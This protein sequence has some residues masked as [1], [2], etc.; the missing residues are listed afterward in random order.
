MRHSIELAWTAADT[1]GSANASRVG[2]A[3]CSYVTLLTSP[4]DSSMP[5]EWPRQ[6]QLLVERQL[7]FRKQLAY[8][9]QR[10]RKVNG[11]LLSESI[12]SIANGRIARL[13]DVHLGFGA[14]PFPRET[15]HFVELAKLSKSTSLLAIADDFEAVS[16]E[17]W[18]GVQL[19]GSGRVEIDHLPGIIINLTPREAS[20]GQPL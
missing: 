5:Q 2:I 3:S 10:R 4:H 13:A 19:L 17:F 7:T 18:D 8:P 16:F 1:A 12:R 15:G 6:P 20:T 11:G 14:V 9:P